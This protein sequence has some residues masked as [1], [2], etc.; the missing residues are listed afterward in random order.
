MDPDRETPQP[1]PRGWL[2]TIGAAIAVAAQVA[3]KAVRDAIFLQHYGGGAGRGRRGL[4]FGGVGSGLLQA[5]C[6]T[7]AYVVIGV[8]LLLLAIAGGG[9]RL[10]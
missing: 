6:A 8:P 10:E 1:V 3:G 5:S 7:V 2:A 4:L 9:P